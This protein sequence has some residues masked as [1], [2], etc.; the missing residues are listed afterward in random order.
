MGGHGNPGRNNTPRFP[1]IAATNFVLREAWIFQVDVVVVLAFEQVAFG[2]P[3]FADDHGAGDPNM[4]IAADQFIILRRKKF[5]LKGD[6]GFSWN[7]FPDLCVG[8]F[9]SLLRNGIPTPVRLIENTDG[10]AKDKETAG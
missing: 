2:F 5:K 8:P 1:A 10:R 7:N 3:R 9:G 6:E 4:E